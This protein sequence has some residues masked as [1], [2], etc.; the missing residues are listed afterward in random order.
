MMIQ[1]D[2]PA[3]LGRLFWLF[4]HDLIAWCGL[5]MG[6]HALTQAIFTRRRKTLANALLAYP[7]TDEQSPTELLYAAG[8]DPQRRPETLTIE[9]MGRLADVVSR[10]H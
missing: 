10:Q 3:R 9:E 6:I 8:I 7:L 4:D 1:M 2:S 5:R